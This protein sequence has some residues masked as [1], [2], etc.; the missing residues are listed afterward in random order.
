MGESLFEY[1]D[2]DGL[3]LQVYHC[4]LYDEYFIRVGEP[5]SSYEN[6]DF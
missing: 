5:D 4:K 3:E 2:A 6:M 1:Q